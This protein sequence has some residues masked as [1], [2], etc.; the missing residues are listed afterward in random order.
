MIHNGFRPFVFFAGVAAALFLLLAAG[1]GAAQDGPGAR[2]SGGTGGDPR[3]IVQVGAFLSVE[4]AAKLQAR[5][6][7]KGYAA[8]VLGLNHRGKDWHA[9][10][11]GSF[12]ESAPAFELAR[13][14]RDSEKAAAVVARVANGR[15]LED[16]VEPPAPLERP[17]EPTQPYRTYL[18][19]G[20]DGKAAKAPAAPAPKVKSPASVP[21]ASASEPKPAEAPAKAQAQAAPAPEPVLTE[22]PDL[23]YVVQIGVFFLYTEAKGLESRYK[24]SWKARITDYYEGNA[25]WHVV[26]I[27]SF[28][29][30]NEAAS[31][32]QSF[33]EKELRAATVKAVVGNK[34]VR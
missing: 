31:R 5:L 25:L 4:N 34:Y 19:K 11:V 14:Y 30:R 10:L 7:A 2:V 17:K 33:M 26:E 3:Y 6:A 9:V 16:V 8:E 24:E 29:D 28:T 20:E 18:D 21:A 27:G 12:P 23:R 13:K 1:P 15:Y 22:N 32:A